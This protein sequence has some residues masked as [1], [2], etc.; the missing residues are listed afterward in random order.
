[1]VAADFV[2]LLLLGGMGQ[3]PK[4]QGDRISNGSLLRLLP[5]AREHD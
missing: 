1:M 5:P 2:N 3:V 4:H